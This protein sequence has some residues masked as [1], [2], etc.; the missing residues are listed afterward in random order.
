MSKTNWAT[1]RV[2]WMCTLSATIP[3]WLS[4]LPPASWYCGRNEKYPTRD[5]AG[6]F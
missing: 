3:N 4:E 2:I 1:G 6:Q 5:V